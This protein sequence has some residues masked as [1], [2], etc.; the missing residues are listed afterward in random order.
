MRTRFPQDEVRVRR[1]WTAAGT[2]V[3]ATIF[4][5][6]AM[7]AGNTTAVSFAAEPST[8]LTA[9]VPAEVVAF[10]AGYCVECHGANKPEANLPLHALSPHP[11]QQAEFEVWSSMLDRIE[12]GEMPPADAK[13]PAITDR[14]Q[15]V[16]KIRELLRQAGVPGIDDLRL[17]SAKG[18]QIDHALLFSSRPASSAGTPTRLWRL[19]GQAYE[20][21]IQQKNAQFKLG[22]RDY[23]EHRIK[24]PW[25][26]T[27]QRD[28]AD[29]ASAHKIGEA[30][31]EF[32][33]RNA[34]QLAQAMV[35]RFA[36]RRPSP[37]YAE[38]IEELNVVLKAREKSSP[39][40]V[41]AAT[42]ATF[43]KLLGRE[44]SEKER[45]RFHGF[46]T[47]NLQSLDAEQAVEQFLIAVLFLPEVTYQIEVLPAGAKREML[48]PQHL[49]RSL[50]FALTD[51]GP[52]EALAHAATEGRLSTRDD[53][54]KQVARMLADPS[55]SKSRILRFFQEYFGHH[56]AP[57]VFK[58][59]V[60]LKDYGIGD[61]NGWH[62]NYFVSDA[63][64]LI[65]WVLAAD[66]N[67]LS[68]LLTTPKTFALTLAPKQ[69]DKQAEGTRQAKERTPEKPW[70]KHE[71]TTLD[72]YELTI[73]SRVDWAH[74]RPF[75]MP[76]E[77]RMGIL[78]HP[79][80]LVAQ[81][82]NFDN[83]A[84]HRGRWIR[85][86]LLGGR[87]PDV[88]VTVNAMLPDEPHRSLRDRMQVTREEYCW[89]CHRRMDPLGLP[90]E[91]FDHFGR[92]RTQEQVVDVEA[93]KTKANL[94]QDGKPRRTI[95]KQVPLDTSGHVEHSGDEQLDGPVGDPFELI[96]KL[97]ESEHVQQVF[98][99]HV[100]RFFMG[101]NETLAD[102]PTLVAA[103]RAYVDGGG[104]MNALITSLLTSDSF[105][106]RVRYRE[107]EKP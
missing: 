30:E 50:A 12:S 98:V 81:S 23:G 1:P 5:V 60:T 3:T 106:Y 84:I 42:T 58:D 63:D 11:T 76:A 15:A 71:Q 22:I 88:P 51:R 14:A 4:Y 95:Y 67:V 8:R 45:D 44:P 53:V 47:K 31:I 78:T 33:L 85:E 80:W 100:F 41:A 26:F 94:N 79:G 93:T 29:Y 107:G 49:A 92:Y 96:R 36:D 102:G 101:R 39:E 25:S 10:V 83:H 19:T 74:D 57:E 54:G 70:Q 7:L 27:P 32:H 82:G 89:K 52:D 9:I 99:R 69:R 6:A 43:V 24:S 18:N 65:E 38:W 28:F 40:Q 20:E 56:A 64:R 13:Q 90:F 59:E 66:K 103:H 16:G 97:A 37:G 105:L 91:Q 86:K 75:E 55:I 35:K 87:I 21:F 77:H 48:A 72:I 104:S 17:A 34:T 61:K 2:L 62:P 46:L 73:P 68:E